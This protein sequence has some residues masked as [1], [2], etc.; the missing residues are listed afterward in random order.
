VTTQAGD[1]GIIG[2]LRILLPFPGDGFISS[3]AQHGEYLVEVSGRLFRA[4]GPH[5]GGGQPGERL[6]AKM[7]WKLSAPPEDIT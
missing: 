1:P 7:Q 6:A 4:P 5:S 2:G 3:V